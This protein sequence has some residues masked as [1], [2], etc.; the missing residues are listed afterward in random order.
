MRICSDLTISGERASDNITKGIA[1]S[2]R[3]SLTALDICGRGDTDAG[4]NVAL[5]FPYSGPHSLLN[6]MHLNSSHGSPEPGPNH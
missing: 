4:G 1:K 3:I 5:E 2:P 6:R